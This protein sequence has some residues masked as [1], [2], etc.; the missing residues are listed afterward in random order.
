M[1]LFLR[2]LLAG[3]WPFGH[4]YALEMRGKVGIWVCSE[5]RQIKKFPT[6]KKAYRDRSKVGK[7]IALRSRR[8]IPSAR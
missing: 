3:C 8:A 1:K 2:R 7:V 5:C 6:V 4:T